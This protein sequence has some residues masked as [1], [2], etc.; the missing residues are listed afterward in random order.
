MAR[1]GNPF[2]S[3]GVGGGGM[4]HLPGYHYCCSRC[5]FPSPCQTQAP[6]ALV[7][8]GGVVV[9]KSSHTPARYTGGKNARISLGL[10]VGPFVGHA[11][12][13]DQE[14]GIV[15]PVEPFGGC[16]WWPSPMEGGEGVKTL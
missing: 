9:V 8:S 14:R 1:G 13:P 5:Y 6:G 12:S 11:S 4:A 15:Y 16:P 7:S 2:G 3:G 10:G